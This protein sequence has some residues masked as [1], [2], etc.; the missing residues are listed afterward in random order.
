MNNLKKY[1]KSQGIT[2]KRF[3]H[4]AS[5]HPTR[6]SLIINKKITPNRNERLKLEHVCNAPLELLLEKEK[7]DV[8]EI[9]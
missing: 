5:I 7:D 4:R 2:N 6:L 1:I 9:N 3:A 8:I